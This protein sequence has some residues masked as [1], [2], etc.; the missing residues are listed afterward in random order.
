[1][2]ILAWF[3]MKQTY[4]PN[5]CIFPLAKEFKFSENAKAI[6]GF[7]GASQTFIDIALGFQRRVL[8][9]GG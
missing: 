9:I 8:P 4:S 2:T 5:V 7:I 6:I 1:M 3:D